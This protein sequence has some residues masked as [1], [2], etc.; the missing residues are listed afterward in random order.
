M[1]SK[2]E[3]QRELEARRQRGVEAEQVLS[4]PLVRHA[5]DALERE[6]VEILKNLKSSDSEGRDTAWRDLQ[7]AS[8]F[9][10]RFAGYVKNGKEA[11]SLLRKLFKD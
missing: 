3:K 5:L 2:E 4:N 6:Q 9:K 8:R 10:E 7:A 11:T 1:K